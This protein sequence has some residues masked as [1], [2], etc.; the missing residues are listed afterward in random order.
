MRSIGK[1]Y[2]LYVSYEVGV[3]DNGVIQYMETDLYTDYGLSSNE[4]VDFLIIPLFENCYDVSTWNFST[5]SV[6]TDMP[7]N[8]I[9]RAPGKI[10]IRSKTH[11]RSF[12]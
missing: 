10:G 12:S 5:Y 8:T 1:R 11:H 4:P 7:P 6:Q 2:P 9:M 3:N